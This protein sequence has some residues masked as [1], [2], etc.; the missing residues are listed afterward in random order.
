MGQRHPGRVREEVTE[1][2]GQVSVGG[3]RTQVHLLALLLLIT[4][5]VGQP[6]R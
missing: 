6:E 4:G 3:E 2:D 1:V 5:P